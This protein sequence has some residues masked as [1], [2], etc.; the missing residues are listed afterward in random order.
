MGHFEL[1]LK[2]KHPA[3][4]MTSH[5]IR[6]EHA[7][8]HDGASAP[9]MFSVSSVLL[10]SSCLFLLDT[11]RFKITH[12]V[13]HSQVVCCCCCKCCYIPFIHSIRFNQKHIESLVNLIKLAFIYR[14]WS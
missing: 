8:G 2:R 4:Q 14:R 6:V 11:D 7:G 10:R 9:V 12:K 13:I 5:T 1:E 3:S